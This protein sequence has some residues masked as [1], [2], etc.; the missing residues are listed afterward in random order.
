MTGSLRFRRLVAIWIPL[1]LTFFLLSGG[2]PVINASINR[3]PGERAEVDLAAF[4]VLLGVALFLHSPLLVTRE[5]AIR[6]SVDRAG[7]RA[8]L[9]FC[10]AAGAV[11]AALELLLGLTPLGRLALLPFAD[12]EEVIAEAHRG[13]ALLSPMPVLIAVRGVF[14]ARQIREDDTKGVA[15]GTGVRLL[16]TGLLGLLLGPH[17]GLSGARLGALCMSFG[18]ALETASVLFQARSRAPLPDHSPRG[19]PKA[20]SF[21]LP[22][23]LANVLGVGASVF[24]LRI[25][26]AVPVAHQ[27][28][29]I[30]AFHQTRSLQWL[31]ASGALALQSLTTAKAEGPGEARAMIRFSCAVGLAMSG[32]FALSILPGAR[33]FILVDLLGE[34]ADGAVAAYATPA[35]ALSSVM[36]FLNALRFSMRGV[37]IARGSTGTISV[38]NVLALLL[39]EAAIRLD[40]TPSRENGAWNVQLWWIAT[41]L[42][43][44]ALMA[45]LG[46]RRRPGPAPLRSPREA[47]G[48]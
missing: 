18:I 16:A 43:E 21:A 23:M 33:T 35:L 4:A 1:A 48:G 17:L 9:R 28:A 45:L 47:T 6:L 30:A 40:L 11:V 36:P 26:A 34:K 10:A 27:A 12:R 13:I 8:A 20:A 46:R 41:L 38:A 5:I 14:H 19:R 2:T 24:Y 22:L 39:L 42:F 37:L 44:I 15:I 29:S 3:L 31:F 32:C 25:A 7:A